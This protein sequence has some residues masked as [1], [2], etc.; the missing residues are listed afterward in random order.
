[1]QDA[2]GKERWIIAGQTEWSALMQEFIILN[3]EEVQS[4]IDMDH[5]LSAVEKAYRFKCDQRAELFPLVCHSFEDGWSEFDIK[6]GSVDGAGVFG[7]KL[8]SAFTRNSEIGLPRLT[9]TILLFDRQTGVLRSMMD[10]GCI[11]N[12]RTGAAGGIGCKVLAR[13]ESKTVLLVGTGAQG[14]TLLAA[15][16][17]VMKEIQKILVYNAH[18]YERA[19]L[20]AEDVKRQ[21]GITCDISATEDLEGAC[22]SADIILTATPSRTALIQTDWI[23]PGTH[24]SCIGSDMEGKQE[25]EETL[26]AKAKVFCDDFAQVIAVGECEKAVKQGLLPPSSITEIGDVLLGKARGREDADEITIFDS[27]GI[28]LQDLMVA[29]VLT[30]LAIEKGIGTKMKL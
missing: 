27:T 14:P 11:T 20:F 8:V 3:Q 13:P 19:S 24:L 17:A 5:V 21:L 23:R 4:M 15:T 22:R 30:D 9:G 12:M 29:S 18:S 25:L 6:S 28:G 10:G 26:L 16:L 1:M 7:M 2:A